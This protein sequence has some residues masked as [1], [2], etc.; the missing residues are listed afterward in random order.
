MAHNSLAIASF[1]ARGLAKLGRFAEARTEYDRCFAT[2]PSATGCISWRARIDANNDGRCDSVEDLGR[3]LIAIDNES[4]EGHHLLAGALF[5]QSQSVIAAHAALEPW[6][7]SLRDARGEWIRRRDETLLER[8][9]R[10]LQRC[11]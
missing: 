3:R 5:A 11:G 2:S 1:Y 10:R 7:L 9:R 8:P 6:W 4:A